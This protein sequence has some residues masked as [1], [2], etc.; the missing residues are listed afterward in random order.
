MQ[1]TDA[2]KVGLVSVAEELLRS[3]YMPEESSPFRD[4]LLHM[5]ASNDCKLAT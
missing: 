5:A 4:S 2:V 3:G 1:L